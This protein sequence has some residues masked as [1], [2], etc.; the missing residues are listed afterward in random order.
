MNTHRN[1]VNAIRIPVINLVLLI[2]EV[3]L[4]ANAVVIPSAI[5]LSKKIAAVTSGLNCTT[6]SK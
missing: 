5:K 2:Y 6:T 1:D 3:C 4:L